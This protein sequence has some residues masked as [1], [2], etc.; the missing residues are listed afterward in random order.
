[1]VVLSSFCGKNY[2][3]RNN[4]RMFMFDAQQSCM[5]IVNDDDAATCAFSRGCSEVNEQP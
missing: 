1:M 5:L 2:I 4:S 3:S